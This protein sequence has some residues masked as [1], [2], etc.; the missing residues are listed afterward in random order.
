[1]SRIGWREKRGRLMSRIGWREER[2]LVWV[3]RWRGEVYE[4]GW[5]RSQ[6]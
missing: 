5:G 6:V 2:V 4:G 1:M 3:S